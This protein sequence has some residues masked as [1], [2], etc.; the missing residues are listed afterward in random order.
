[1]FATFQPQPRERPPQKKPRQVSL[2]DVTYLDNVTPV[3]VFSRHVLYM[4]DRVSAKIASSGQ[5]SKYGCNRQSH[6]GMI[7]V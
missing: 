3:R 7:E 1:M 5:L 6:C 4:A 2:K